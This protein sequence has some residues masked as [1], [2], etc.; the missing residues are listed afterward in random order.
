[1][2]RAQVKLVFL[3]K[4][5]LKY[6]SLPTQWRPPNLTQSSKVY[7]GYRAWLQRCCPED[8]NPDYRFPLNTRAKYV[9]LLS[10]RGAASS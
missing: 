2:Q 6:G 10:M 4:P 9:H 7:F 3:E 5:E 8:S 1:M